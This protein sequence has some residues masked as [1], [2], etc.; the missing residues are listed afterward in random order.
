MDTQPLTRSCQI[1]ED[2][3]LPQFT[4]KLTG[5]AQDIRCTSVSHLSLAMALVPSEYMRHPHLASQF[6][7][8]SSTIQ[9]KFQPTSH[10]FSYPRQTKTRN[11]DPWMGAKLDGPRHAVWGTLQYRITSCKK[12]WKAR[13]QNSPLMPLRSWTKACLACIHNF[14]FFL[15]VVYPVYIPL[16]AANPCGDIEY[17]HVVGPKEFA[18]VHHDAVP[19]PAII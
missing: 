16:W 11:A 2:T 5:Y 19:S 13:M 4:I 3:I 15:F 17:L 9:Q 6:S 18:H 7:N 8:P 12:P 14:F 1:I 10:A